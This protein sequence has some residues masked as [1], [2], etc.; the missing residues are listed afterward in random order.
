MRTHTNEHK[1]QIH[2][3]DYSHILNL[4]VK[5]SPLSAAY[6]RQWT[7][8]SLVHVIAC[9]LF[10]AKPLPKPMLAYYQGD[11]WEHGNK[12]QINLDRNSVILNQ[13]NA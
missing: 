12:F 8:S 7:G 4:C 13:E 2:M 6:M 11:L 3:L 10:G 9:C 5:S 1:H